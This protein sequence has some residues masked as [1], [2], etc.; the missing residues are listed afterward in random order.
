MSPDGKPISLLSGAIA[1]GK[2]ARPLV[3]CHA[4]TEDRFIS[5]MTLIFTFEAKEIWRKCA[6]F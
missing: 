1:H 5:S 4:T 6:V 3:E 2:A